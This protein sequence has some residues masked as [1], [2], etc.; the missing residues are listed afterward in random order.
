MQIT[1]QLIITIAIGLSLGYLSI[2]VFTI[3]KKGLFVFIVLLIAFLIDIF[4]VEKRPT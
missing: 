4:W 2:D 1:K 3:Y